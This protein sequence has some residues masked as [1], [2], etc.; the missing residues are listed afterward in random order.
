[1]L[2]AIV[3]VVFYADGD[4]AGAGHRDFVSLPLLHD[5]VQDGSGGLSMPVSIPHV[6]LLY[7]CCQLIYQD[8]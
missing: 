5:V 6:L 7:L 1:M 2:G 4:V 8:Q 3:E